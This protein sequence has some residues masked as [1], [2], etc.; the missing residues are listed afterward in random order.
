MKD[1]Y[2]QKGGDVLAPFVAAC[3]H[4]AFFVYMRSVPLDVRSEV[5]H[6]RVVRVVRDDH[7]TRWVG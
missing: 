2:S 5:F 6:D 1:G 4:G 7:Q 3:V